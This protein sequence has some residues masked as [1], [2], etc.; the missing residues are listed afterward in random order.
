MFSTKLFEKKSRTL[1]KKLDLIMMTTKR[2]MV[3]EIPILSLIGTFNEKQNLM[4]ES[5][6]FDLIKSFKS[7]KVL[8]KWFRTGGL[9]TSMNVAHYTICTRI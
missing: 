5:A 3:T 8:G 1:K 7:F 9:W 6:I 4:T 2:K